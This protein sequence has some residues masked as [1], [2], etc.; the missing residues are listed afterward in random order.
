MN[1]LLVCAAVCGLLFLEGQ[2]RAADYTPTPEPEAVEGWSGFYIGGGVGRSHFE[3]GDIDL[4]S[5]SVSGTCSVP[6]NIG[7][8]L[9]PGAED[10]ETSAHILAGYMFRSGLLGLG[11]EGDYTFGDEEVGDLSCEAPGPGGACATLSFVN[12]LEHQARLRAIAGVE[13][14]PFFLFLAAGVAIA[15]VSSDYVLQGVLPSGA[16][17]SDSVGDED[18]IAGPTFGVGV[19]VHVTDHFAVRGEFITDM[20]PDVPSPDGTVSVSVPGFAVSSTV[21]TGGDIDIDHSVGRISAIF[22]F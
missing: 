11:I 22:N 13:A 5:A 9:G 7:A 17:F 18:T 15:H 1:R 4:D 20:Y 19:Q 14:G 3:R 10:D 6:C 12:E 16:S 8:F 2:A 21:S